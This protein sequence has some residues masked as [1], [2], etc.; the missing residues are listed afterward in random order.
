MKAVLRRWLILG[1]GWA[2]LVLGIAGL[3]VPT[4]QGIL[5][6]LI[7]PVLLSRE[8]IWIR[9]RLEGWGGAPR[10]SEPARANSPATMAKASA[11]Q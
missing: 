10:Y 3:F 5:F 4:L 9:R 2:S 11:R 1:L 8:S 7:G 6:I